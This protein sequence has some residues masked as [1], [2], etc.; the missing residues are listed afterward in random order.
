MAT[1]QELAK[2]YGLQLLN[3]SDKEAEIKRIVSAIRGLTYEN[4]N[5]PISS[6]HV[7][8]ILELMRSLP[9]VMDT[10]EGFTIRASDNTEYISLV[11][12]ISDILKED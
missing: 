8:Q 12:T 11:D 4:T 5:E 1:F 7:G 3:A 10:T 9:S 6:A 2:Q